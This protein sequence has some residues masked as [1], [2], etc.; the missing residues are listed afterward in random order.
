[1][2]GYFKARRGISFTLEI[3]EECL[4]AAVRTTPSIIIEVILHVVI[5][6]V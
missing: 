3:G 2:V 6:Q 1:M 5:V 4:E